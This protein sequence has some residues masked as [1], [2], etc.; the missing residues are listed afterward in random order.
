MNFDTFLSKYTEN[1]ELRVFDDEDLESNDLLTERINTLEDLF[2]RLGGKTFNN[3]LVRVCTKKGAYKLTRCFEKMYSNGKD[4]ILVFAFDWLG[5]HFAID[6]T[7]KNSTEDQTFLLEPGSGEHLLIP[8]G[9]E[10]FFNYI[11][12]N[13]AQDALAAES[14]NE[15]FNI[16]KTVIGFDECVGYKVPLFLGGDDDFH[17]F[18]ITNTEVY[19]EICIQLLHRTKKLK[20]GQ[21]INSIRFEDN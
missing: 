7:G 10:G 17:N 9:V 16:S 21:T 14:F 6:Y 20:P 3:G 11:L 4:N 8:A 2:S 19:I 5:R 18:E 15:W 12:I 13:L 1:E